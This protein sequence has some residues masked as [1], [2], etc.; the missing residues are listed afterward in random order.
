MCV[1]VCV[2]ARACVCVRACV[3]ACVCVVCVCVVWCVRACVTFYLSS[4]IGNYE[5]F[6]RFHRTYFMNRNK[7]SEISE[8]Q[9]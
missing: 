2:R 4:S 6:F 8:A 3:C 5:Y 7:I 9:N 1:C